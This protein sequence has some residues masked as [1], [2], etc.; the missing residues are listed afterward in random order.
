MSRQWRNPPVRSNAAY[1][2]ITL[3]VVQFDL[4]STSISFL[5][6]HSRPIQQICLASISLQSAVCWGL[7]PSVFSLCTE[8]RGVRN[9]MKM[10]DISF[11]KND[12]K[13]QKTENSVSMVRFS[14]NDF[15]SL[16]LVFQVVSFTIHLAAWYYQHSKYFSSCRISALLVLSHFG[17]QLV[18]PIQQGSTSFLASYCRG[19][20]ES[21]CRNTDKCRPNRTEKNE[22]VVNFVKLKTEPKSFF[23]NCTPLTETIEMYFMPHDCKMMIASVK[24]VMNIPVLIV[25]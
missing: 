6:S 3:A 1:H 14:K 20:N 8:T 22:T 9:P 18:G 25:I 10:S 12:L 13:I 5:I 2:Q 23:A 15:G 24:M 16:G 4:S 7:F 19:V 21:W 17:C 11:L